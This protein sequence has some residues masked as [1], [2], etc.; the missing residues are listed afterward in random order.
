M[1]RRAWALR[2]A[3]RV[4]TI[5]LCAA[6]A[7]CASPAKVDRS[8][9]PPGAEDRIS[10]LPV[11]LDE[12]KIDVGGMF[13]SS[14]VAERKSFITALEGARRTGDAAA[15][16][17]A[18]ALFAAFNISSTPDDFA[19]RLV[20]GFMLVEMRGDEGTSSLEGLLTGYA[21][22]VVAARVRRDDT[23]RFPLIGDIRKSAPE[24]L[25]APRREILASPK[26]L[27]GA[28]AWVD[29]PATWAL[30]ETNGT[31]RL[32]IEGADGRAR[33]KLI[34]RAATNGRPWTGLGRALAARGLLEPE[35][36]TLADVL[37]V[38]RENP[39]A[40]E[41]AAMD[42]ERLVYFGEVAEGNFPPALGIRGARLMGGYSCAADQSV[43]PPGSVLVIVRKRADAKPDEP[44]EARL[45]F[46]MDAGGAIKGPGR[47]DIYLGQGT[48][49]LVRAGALRENVAVYR[50]VSRTR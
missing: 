37:R 49:S 20:D 26:A 30:V 38:S 17:D 32:V 48:E 6:L 34:S 42:N 7:G 19:R 11:R 22:P 47:I 10:A 24:L 21:T 35:G 33:E 2:R 44:A 31:A 43:Y 14:D 9:Q 25:A 5:V 13:P 36:F 16:A 45:A 8:L 40:A 50:L 3:D 41:E 28:I 15:A 1:R 12:R 4:A 39:A 46:V 23:F 18:G 29:D 27:A